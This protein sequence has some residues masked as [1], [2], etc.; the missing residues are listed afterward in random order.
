MVS[1][2]EFLIKYSI[3]FDES[4][5]QFLANLRNFIQQNLQLANSVSK[6]LYNYGIIEVNERCCNILCNK[7]RK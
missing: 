7:D 4:C 2:I 5:M 1:A 6:F 3:E